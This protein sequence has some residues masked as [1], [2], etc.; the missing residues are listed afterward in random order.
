MLLAFGMIY[1]IG[2]IDHGI[3]AFGEHLF[4]EIFSGY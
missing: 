2:T 1:K 4:S 3:I